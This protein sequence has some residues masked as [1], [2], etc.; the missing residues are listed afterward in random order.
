M[1]TKPFGVAFIATQGNI[2]TVATTRQLAI[3]QLVKII[4]P[5]GKNGK[6]KV[7]YTLQKEAT[8]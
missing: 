1:K 2:S 7:V 8:K 6:T 5:I 4:F 3:H